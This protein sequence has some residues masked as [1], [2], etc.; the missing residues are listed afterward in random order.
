MIDGE[1]SGLKETGKEE[2]VLVLVSLQV[3]AEEGL[4]DE[5][6]EAAVVGSGG[7]SAEVSGTRRSKLFSPSLVLSPW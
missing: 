4:E 5:E 7:L 1:K 6:E 2:G 3:V